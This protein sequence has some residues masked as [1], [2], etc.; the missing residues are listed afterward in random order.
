VKLADNVYLLYGPS[1]DQVFR[2]VADDRADDLAEMVENQFY[3]QF[4]RLTNG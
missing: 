1:V 3:R 4:A 2:L